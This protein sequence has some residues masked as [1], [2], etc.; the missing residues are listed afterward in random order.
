M[1]KLDELIKQFNK[2]HKDNIASKGVSRIHIP[3]I[4]FSS[5]RAN[6]MTY[7][8]I[9]RGRITEFAGEEASG[10]TTTALDI[11]AQGQ[12]LFQDEWEQ[13]IDDVQY[14]LDNDKL[15]AAVGREKEATLKY[16]NSRGPLKSLYVDSENTLDSEWAEKLGVNVDDM[17]LLRPFEQSAEQIFQM[18]LDAIDTGEMGLMV[19]DSIGTLVSQQAMDKTMEEKSYC[20]VAGPLTGFCN[21]VTP[22]LNKHKCTLIGINQVREDISNPYN[23]YNTPGGK[24]WKHH[25]SLR[26]MF[27]KGA[28]IDER[29]KELKRSAESP[30]GNLVMLSIAKTKIC[31]PD[32]RTGF[33]TLNY[34]TGIDYVYDTVETALKYGL[35]SGSGWYT[36]LDAKGKEVV[37]KNGDVIKIQGKDNVTEYLQNNPELFDQI[38]QEI[39]RLLLS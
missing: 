27:Q 21:K 39:G 25:C 32:R 6:Y 26:M 1:S 37:D 18:M 8:G 30:A 33:Y 12:L 29:C 23:L 36:F 38:Y 13:Q 24:S 9:G 2:D 19:L 14:S 20:G 4:P 15:S 10:K 35:I 22:R 5:P 31:K 11:V 28:F 34:T 3:R 17:Y 16:L 7:G